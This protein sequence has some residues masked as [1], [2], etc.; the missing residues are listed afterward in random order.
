MTVQY[1]NPEQYA[2][3]W[4]EK[5]TQRMRQAGVSQEEIDENTAI[6][7]SFIKTGAELLIQDP[8]IEIPDTA[9]LDALTT[10]ETKEMVQFFH[11]EEPFELDIPRFNQLIELFVRSV[12]L[13]AKTLR[14]RG[15]P[16]EARRPILEQ[17]A[18]ETFTLAKVIIAVYHSP[19]SKFRVID[20][21]DKMAQEIMRQGTMEILQRYL[22]QPPPPRR[23]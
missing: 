19:R 11:Q 14:A 4:T 15:L 10:P 12:N 16:W 7:Q 22:N 9:G 23:G 8:R 17:A 13:M 2:R 6:L 3:Q 5:V 18:W 20:P 21:E 1:V